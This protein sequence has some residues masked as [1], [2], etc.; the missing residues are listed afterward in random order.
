MCVRLRVNLS[1]CVRPGDAVTSN[2]NLN[3]VRCPFGEIVLNV[4]LAVICDL[5]NRPLGIIRPLVESVNAVSTL[6]DAVDKT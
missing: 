5:R 1:A 4:N 6:V 2:N 3:A